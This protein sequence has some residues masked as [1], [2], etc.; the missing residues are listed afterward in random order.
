VGRESFY[1]HF[2]DKEDC[3]IAANEALVDNLAA[4]VEEAYARPGPWPE[5]V[6]S[7]L[8]ETLR[9]FAANPEI[10]RVMMMEMGTVGPAAGERFR[11]TFRRF[12]ALL[13][14][15]TEQIENAPDLPNIASIAGGAVFARV[16][17]EVSRGGAASLPELLPEL[18]FEL[19]L[20][21]IGEEAANQQRDEA[22][23]QLAREPQ[24]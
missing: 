2:E 14:E 19:L 21:Y 11:D 16:Y 7:G 5:R 15:G 23:A 13:D 3:F 24:P 18:T 20:P 17:E 9:W 4:Q 10:A 12:T 8:A 6:R 22:A 1:K